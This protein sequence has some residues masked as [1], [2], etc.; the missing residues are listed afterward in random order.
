ML[1]FGAMFISFCD[2]STLFICIAGYFLKYMK[3]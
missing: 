1:G 2:F 3:L